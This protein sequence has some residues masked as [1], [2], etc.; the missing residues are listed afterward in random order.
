[1]EPIDDSATEIVIIDDVPENLRLLSTFL[2]RN[3]HHVRAYTD[4]KLALAAVREEP[5]QL[6][7]LDINM[8]GMSGYEVCERLKHDSQLAE[9]PIIFISGMSDVQDIVKGFELG[10]VDYVT[11]P[12]QFA[13]VQARVRT[14]LQLR[15]LQLQLQLHNQQLYTLIEE[16][17]REVL[18]EKERVSRAQ[19]ATIVAMSKLA[20]ARDDD[21]GQHIERTREYCKILA[22]HLLK[23]KLYPGEVDA[24]YVETIYQAAPLHDIGKVAISDAILRKPGKLTDEEFETM[25]R[26]AEFGA[27]TLRRV[28]AQY[29]DNAFLAMGIAIA[30]S[31]HEKWN[32][33]GY[34]L[35]LK[36]E[37]IPLPGR[38]MAIA[39]VYD[40]LRSK[41]CYKEG[42][43][44]EKSMGI[45]V[46]DAGTHFDPQLIEVL[47]SIEKE[48]N[49]IHE[50]WS[51][52][53]AQPVIA[54]PD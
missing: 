24:S 27:E 43:S 26:H 13:E 32:G 35:G 54:N 4:P 16:K 28:S 11:K 50:A 47:S 8:P 19:L 34:P 12:F 18:R 41:R 6:I 9:I 29:P 2:T 53:T 23:R 38:I 30:S 15:A 20:E 51:G 7:L 10:G 37:A 48:F 46:N 14:H 49:A 31:H 42:F 17:M 44:H 1:M 21:T 39:D 36:A 22:S 40:A 45:M 5:P 3:G 25:K 33:M 52:G